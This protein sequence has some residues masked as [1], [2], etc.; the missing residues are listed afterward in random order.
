MKNSEKEKK[1]LGWCVGEDISKTFLG[2]GEKITADVVDPTEIS[3]ALYNNFVNIQS[4]RYWFD[5][6]AWDKFKLF[7]DAKAASFLNQCS[8]CSKVDTSRDELI[9]IIVC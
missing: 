9:A 6:D 7:F 2:S 5:S 3:P 8:S 4:I 1:V